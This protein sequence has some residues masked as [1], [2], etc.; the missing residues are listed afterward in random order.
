[1]LPLEQRGGLETY[2][3]LFLYDISDQGKCSA[4]LISQQ[5]TNLKYPKMC[6]LNS[7][8]LRSETLEFFGKLGWLCYKAGAV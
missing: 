4:P 2:N 6:A 8:R 7:N 5:T 1:M 3:Q